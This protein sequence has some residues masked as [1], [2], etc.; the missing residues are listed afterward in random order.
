MNNVW[1]VVH[2]WVVVWSVCLSVGRSVGRSNAHAHGH[3]AS[4]L[5]FLGTITVSAMNEWHHH[6]WNGSFITGFDAT[7]IEMNYFNVRRNV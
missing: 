4:L 3:D 6:F 2:L 5:F 7:I 1:S